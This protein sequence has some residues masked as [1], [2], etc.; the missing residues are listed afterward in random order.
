MKKNHRDLSFSSCM[1][2]GLDRGHPL[3]GSFS[4]F[5]S[6]DVDTPGMSQ[7]DQ[8]FTTFPCG[9]RIPLVP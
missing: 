9:S 5:L 6:H 3:I 2:E 8:T 1:E 7:Y 4:Q